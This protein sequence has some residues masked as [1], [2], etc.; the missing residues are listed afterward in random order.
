MRVK[1]KQETS[2]AD[3]YIEVPASELDH[4]SDL[5]DWECLGAQ[6]KGIEGD[7]SAVSLFKVLL[8][9]SWFSLSDAG[10]A[11][12]LC[13]DIVFMRFVG[14]SLDGQKP[15]ASTICRYRTRLIQSGQLDHLLLQINE[16][17]SCQGLKVSNGKYVSCDATLISST[18]RPRKRLEG[19]AEDD[20]GYTADEVVYSD[21]TE[22][23]WKSKGHQFVYGY[24]G[25]V[26]TDEDG[27]V[28]AVSTRTA[29]ESE[30]RE[31]PK[32]MAEANL[33][34]GKVVLYDKGVDSEANREALKQ[35]GLRDGIMR[36][37]PKGKAMS[38]WNQLRNRL[39]STRRFV[40]ERTFGTLKRTYGLHRA[41]Y[42]GLE[43]VNGEILLKSM[44][45]NLKR[46]Y[47]YLIEP[48][49]RPQSSCV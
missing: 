17:L 9:Q 10:V 18:R 35:L 16:N 14:F 48:W 26:T 6:L 19:K 36:K 8:L 5:I 29:K 30:M 2:F 47:R 24:A 32:V 21:D 34:T 3:Q 1:T 39:I 44:A 49:R 22:A 37:K 38:H 7:Y 23:S 15:T 43:K 4:L 45:Y 25:Y 46:A 33:P 42:V 31:F 27:L 40:T 12:A 11:S 28:E 41:R 13:R 20:D